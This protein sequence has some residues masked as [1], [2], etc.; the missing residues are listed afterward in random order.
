LDFIIFFHLTSSKKEK[1]RY[2]DITRFD[3][4]ILFLLAM[5]FVQSMANNSFLKEYFNPKQL[6][7]RP[8]VVDPNGLAHPLV[9]EFELKFF[10]RNYAQDI[11]NWMNK[12]WWLSFIYAFIYVVLIFFGQKLMKSRERFEARLPLTLWNIGLALFSLLGMLRCVPEMIYSLTT[13]GLQFTICDRSN[14][15]GITGY[16]FVKILK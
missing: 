6:H 3:F 11:Y 2:T 15:H 14:I 4:R 12:W 16:W 9:F 7:V 13:E 5:E 1:S 8:W 10:D